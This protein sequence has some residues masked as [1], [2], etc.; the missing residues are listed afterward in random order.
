M[1]P[2]T[3]KPRARVAVAQ[4]TST[5]DVAHNL[6]TV[7][8]L[9]AQ[10]AEDRA[11]MLVLPECFAYLG[12]EHGK[13]GVAEPLPDG[14]P[15]L[16]HCRELAIR[17]RIELVLGGFW[18]RGSNPELVRNACVH[19]SAGGD[20]LAVYR[21]IHLFDVDLA[22]GTKLRESETVEP[23]TEAVATEALFGMLGL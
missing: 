16:T 3:A 6:A 15:I 14:G 19:L 7:S 18:E 5:A 22:D 20:V 4:M 12:P 9:A 21:K 1:T 10:A 8:E 11:A 13:L 23:G 2:Q 17:H